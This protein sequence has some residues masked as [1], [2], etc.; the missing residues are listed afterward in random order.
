MLEKT[1]VMMLEESKANTGNYYLNVSTQTPSKMNL[2]LLREKNVLAPKAI[3][4]LITKQKNKFCHLI[5]SL[6]K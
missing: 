2:L 5:F 4:K 6:I 3:M 1:A